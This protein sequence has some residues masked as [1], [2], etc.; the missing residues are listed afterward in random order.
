MTIL[1]FKK[2]NKKR[3]GSKLEKYKDEILELHNSN[4]SQKLIVEFLAQNNIKTS[5]PNVSKFLYKYRNIDIVEKSETSVKSK[6][7]NSKSK[8]KDEKIINK[9]NDKKALFKDIDF[10][11]KVGKDTDIKRVDWA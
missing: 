2:T 7:D 1:E 10:T 5:Q 9:N 3:V 6:V 11:K 4:V 8:E